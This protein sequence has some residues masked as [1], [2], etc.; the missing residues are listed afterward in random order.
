MIRYGCGAEKVTQNE[1]IV[2]CEKIGKCKCNN[3]TLQR[4]GFIHFQ[5]SSPAKNNCELNF[6]CNDSFAI[7]STQQ[8][9][10]QQ[11]QTLISLK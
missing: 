11:H 8:Q 10:H 1:A 4:F 5:Y 7:Q 9:Q 2:N 6:W 3:N